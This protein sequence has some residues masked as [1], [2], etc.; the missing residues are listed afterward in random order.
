MIT[1]WGIALVS[2][3]EGLGLFI[4]MSYLTAMHSNYG[5][6][7]FLERDFTTA[8]HTAFASFSDGVSSG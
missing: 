6:V 4:G 1:F 8:L 3:K 2:V 7:V 5:V